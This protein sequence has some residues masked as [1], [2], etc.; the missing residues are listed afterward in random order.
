[1]FQCISVFL[2]V[3]YNL[4]E[5]AMLTNQQ[6]EYWLVVTL[7]MT[8]SCCS[9]AVIVS[10][11]PAVSSH[12]DSTACPDQS[13]SSEVPVSCESVDNKIETGDSAAVDPCTRTSDV[14]AAS[15]SPPD[16]QSVAVTSLSTVSNTPPPS[17]AAPALGE[18]QSANISQQGAPL[19]HGTDVSQQGAPQ[20]ADTDLAAMA[21]SAENIYHVKWIKFRG[22]QTPIVMQNQNGPCPLLAVVNVLLLQG[23]IKLSASADLVASDQ[24]MAYIAD[25]IFDNVPKVSCVCTYFSCVIF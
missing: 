22:A 8:M 19:D 14:T 3:Q 2:N 5:G 18:R 23:K 17:D 12:N 21:A 9:A 10:D 20:E 16:V 24:L 15:V 11:C 25:W 6:T 13:S 7:I 1:M 4:I